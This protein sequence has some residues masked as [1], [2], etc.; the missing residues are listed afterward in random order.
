MKDQ[1]NELEPA[2]VSKVATPAARQ[3]GDIQDRWSWVERTVWTDRMLAALENGVKGGKWLYVF[4]E[5]QGLFSLKSAHAQ[6]R[7]SALR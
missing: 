4:F 3:A 6:F 5:E 1:S 7:Q 2:S